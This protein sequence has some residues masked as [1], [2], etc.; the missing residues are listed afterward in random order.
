MSMF[1]VLSKIAWVVLTPSNLLVAAGVVGALL[2]T[3]RLPR[4][5]RS[6]LIGAFAGFFILGFSPAANWAMAALENRFPRPELTAVADV[7]GIIVLGGATRTDVSK[8]RGTLDLNEAAERI[9]AI[10]ALARRFP[11]ARII[12]TGGSA[13]LFGDPASEADLMIAALASIGV[14]RARLVREGSARNTFE[15]ATET[16][17]RIQPKAGETYLLVTSAFHMPRAVGAFRQA[18]WTGLLPYPVDFRTQGAADRWRP[19]AAASNGL[20]RFDTAA[21]EAVGLLA[22]W[23]TGR[24]EALFPLP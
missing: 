10:P 20:K 13:A 16:F 8:A 2:F 19:F 11:K 23:L 14:D 6:L 15:N 21:R 12:L 22:Y 5:G 9:V 24:T 7:D 4:L 18:G 1:F 3:G 17:A